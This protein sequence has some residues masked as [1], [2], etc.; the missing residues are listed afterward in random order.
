MLAEAQR[1]W[2]SGETEGAIGFLQEKAG[3]LEGHAYAVIQHRLGE[4]ALERRNNA[5]AARAFGAAGRTRARA[6]AHVRA[7]AIRQLAT[8]REGRI[9]RP[10]GLFEYSKI[11]VGKVP[12]PPGILEECQFKTADL[13]VDKYAVDFYRVL[14]ESALTEEKRELARKRVAERVEP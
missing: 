2:E 5:L 13:L 6:A 11:A 14:A 10:D 9:L 8:I 3:S 12:A 7:S 4:Y 1:L